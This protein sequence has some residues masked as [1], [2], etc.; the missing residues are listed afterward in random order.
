MDNVSIQYCH[1]FD[2]FELKA[3]AEYKSPQCF[4]CFRLTETMQRT[5]S[6]T[7][8]VSSSVPLSGSRGLGEVSVVVNHT[9]REEN[10]GDLTGGSSSSQVCPR[11]L[12]F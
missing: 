4:V 2:L 12:D 11:R 1:I 9:T 6:L 8:S 5:S 7:I 3:N 10:L